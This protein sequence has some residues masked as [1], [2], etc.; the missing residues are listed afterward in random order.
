MKSY[1]LSS[2]SAFIFASAPYL[3]YFLASFTAHRSEGGRRQNRRQRKVAHHCRA[4]SEHEGRQTPGAAHL[5]GQ[6][7]G[8]GESQ[9]CQH[10]R[11]RVQAVQGREGTRIPAGCSRTFGCAKC[12][13][14]ARGAR[15]PW[16]TTVSRTRC[17]RGTTPSTT[18][19]CAKLRWG[20]QTRHCFS[21]PEA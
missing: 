7:H 19:A 14:G 18:R 13:T 3:L 6:G 2:T 4:C 5:Q 15:G 10:H 8:A 21:S 9:G 17:L 11:A 12:G 16:A 1:H 20:S